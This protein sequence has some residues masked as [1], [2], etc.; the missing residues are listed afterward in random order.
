MAAAAQPGQQPGALRLEGEQHH[1]ALRRLEH[2]SRHRVQRRRI[3]VARQG[4]DVDIQPEPRGG[5]HETFLQRRAIAVLYHDNRGRA[6]VQHPGQVERQHLAQVVVLEY[7][8]EGRGVLGDDVRRGVG[9]QGD[10]TT[11][12]ISGAGGQRTRA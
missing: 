10:E 6:A 4:I 3:C 5:A 12:G 2:F 8:P 1:R 9:R 7:D 11:D